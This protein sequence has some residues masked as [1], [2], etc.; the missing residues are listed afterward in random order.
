LPAKGDLALFP[1][2]RKLGLIAIVCIVALRMAIGWHFYKE[3][4]QKFR[5]PNWNSAGFLTGAKGPLAPW[6]LSFAPPLPDET[7]LNEQGVIEVWN[8]FREEATSGYGYE[9]PD[10]LAPLE[11]EL[12][13][14]KS[15]L[16]SAES[17]EDKVRAEA[18]LRIAEERVDTFKHQSKAAEEAFKRRQSQVQHF[19]RSNR[20]DIDN[21]LR[22][23]AWL[24]SMKSDATTGATPFQQERIATKEAEVRSKARD[25]MANLGQLNEAFERDL[26]N[27][28]T[29]QQRARGVLHIRASDAAWVDSVVKWTVLLVGVFLMLGLFAR[30]AAIVGALF[31][32]SV[33]AVAGWPFWAGENPQ[34][35]NVLVE[36]C[37]LL[38]LAAIGAGRFAGLDF[39]LYA[40]WAKIFGNRRQAGEPT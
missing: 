12:A 2:F 26:Y 31:L 23:L 19:F 37:A 16:E 35:Y 30:P 24:E 14:A 21:Y 28:A 3:G 36:L 32:S 10:Y 6:F 5:D 7:R 22:E 39:F 17:E 1:Q 33:L 13:V 15:Q 34:T 8:V 20:E 40:L 38:A 11:Q 18:A 25:L 9:S 27:L 4:V 29:P